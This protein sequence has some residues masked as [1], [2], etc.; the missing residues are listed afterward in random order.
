MLSLCIYVMRSRDV[1]PRGSLDSGHTAAARKTRGP[2]IAAN[3]PGPVAAALVRGSQHVHFQAP[4]SEPQWQVPPRAPRPHRCPVAIPPR[5][6]SLV[7]L[8]HLWQAGE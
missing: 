7:A 1:D 2:A 6:L 8:T 4:Q 3:D 5:W